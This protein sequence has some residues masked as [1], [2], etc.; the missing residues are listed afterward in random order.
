MLTTKN[1]VENILT[2]FL[3][4]AVFLAGCTPPGVRSLLRGKGLIER[5]RYAEAIEELRVGA[6]LLGTNAQVWNYLGLAYH[7]S[8]QTTNAVQ[9]YQKALTLDQD[10]AEAHHNLGCLWLEQNRW[11]LAKPELITYTSLRK[12]SVEGWLKLGTAQLR[13]FRSVT[14][15]ARPLELVAAEK[16]YGEALRLNPQNPEAWNGLGLVQL[17]RN[18]PREAVQHFNHA[19]EQQPDYAPGLLNLAVV[20]QLYLNN[21][22]LAL[23]KYREYLALPVRFPNADA[24]AAAAGELAQELNP[25]ARTPATNRTSLPATVILQ[26]KPPTN[27][28][29]RAESLPR[30]APAT[31]AIKA[32]TS[33][34]SSQPSA[35]VVRIP[36]EPAAKPAQDVVPPSAPSSVSKTRI[37]ST[38][39]KTANTNSAAEKQG[40]LSRILHRNSK[41][42][43]TA[44]PNAGVVSLPPALGSNLESGGTAR[45]RYHSPPKPV[46]G[47]AASA[48]RVFAQGLQAQQ[49]GH[50]PEAIQAYR[51][52]TQLDP[53]DY[54]AYYNLGLAAA[55]QGDLPLALA[56]YEYALAIR[57]ESADSRYNFALALKKA[58]YI[59][60]AV[61]ELDKLLAA[62]PDEPRAHLALGNIYAQQLHQPAR[63]REHYLKVLEDDPR[64]PQGDAIRYWLIANPP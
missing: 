61:R 35:E 8:G 36:P 7:Y 32:A 34:A 44:S 30:V 58:D 38:A 49:A 14:G 13:S 9:A 57:P 53:A 33:T 22:P 59:Q 1:A 4:L 23:Q 6:S 24:A 28:A 60:D 47:D 45:Y 2:F 54:D 19:L 51:Q 20:W 11:D 31:N 27:T 37:A 62:Y 56:A 41:P 10:L 50:R 43:S 55:A 21:H 63:A 40:F 3:L 29:V 15:A 64:N 48:Q 39:P 5:G 46:A 16:S 18:R 42:N 12:N 25:P 52:A 26:A 17:Q